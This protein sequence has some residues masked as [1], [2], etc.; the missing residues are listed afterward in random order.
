[1]GTDSAV[2]NMP[3]MTISVIKLVEKQSGIWH[4]AIFICSYSND[5]YDISSPSFA[6]FLITYMN[7]FYRIIATIVFRE[8]SEPKIMWTLIQSQT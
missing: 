1:M 7:N 5:G 4:A 6:K 3:L 8:L 2:F